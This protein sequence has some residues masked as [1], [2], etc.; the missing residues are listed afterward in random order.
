MIDR[1]IQTTD[2]KDISFKN[3]KHFSNHFHLY[4]PDEKGIR[5]FFSKD[6]ILFFETHSIYHIESSGNSILVFPKE[7]LAKPHQIEIM[8]AFVD[9]LLVKISS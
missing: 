2:S 3:F 8:M 9:E 4:G 7:K 6:I 1:V 5:E